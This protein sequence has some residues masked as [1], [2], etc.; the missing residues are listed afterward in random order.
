MTTAPR[1]ILT[2]MAIVAATATAVAVRGSDTV[3][4]IPPAASIDD[5]LLHEATREAVR[6]GLA[7]LAARA[8][9]EGN[10]DGY[11]RPMYVKLAKVDERSVE[12]RYSKKAF[13]VPT[14]ARKYREVEQLVPI[15]DEYGDVTGYRK[16]TRKIEVSK[17]KTGEKK[18]VREVRDPNGPIVK[19]MKIPIKERVGPAV[20]ERG[21]YGENAIAVYVYAKAGLGDHEVPERIADELASLIDTHGAPDTTWDLAWLIAAYA[22]LGDEQY[23]ELLTQLVSKLIDGQVRH[24]RSGYAGLWGPV[25]I[26]YPL[27]ANFFELELRVREEIKRIENRMSDLEPPMTQ[28]AKQLIDRYYEALGEIQMMLRRASQLGLT[29]QKITGTVKL[30][31]ETQIQGLPIFVYNRFLAD[32]DATAAAG[33]ALYA[34]AAAE[35]LPDASLRIAPAGKR[36]VAAESTARTIADALRALTQQQQRDGGWNEVNALE[37]NTTFDRS[38]IAIE[39]V[40]LREPLPTLPAFDTLA[41]DLAGYSAL[42]HL[43]LAEPRGTRLYAS[44]VQSARAP[45]LEAAEKILALPRWS[46]VASPVDVAAAQIVANKGPRRSMPRHAADADEEYIGYGPGPYPLLIHA[47]ALFRHA[48]DVE[49]DAAVEAVRKRLTLRILRQQR[50][51]GQWSARQGYGGHLT[52]SEI[53]YPMAARASVWRLKNREVTLKDAKRWAGNNV[54]ARTSDTALYPTLAALVFLVE[55]IEEPVSLDDVTILPEKPDEPEGKPGE[56]A[57]DEDEALMSPNEAASATLRPNEALLTLE[58][59]IDRVRGQGE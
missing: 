51:D 2:C 4:P 12:V 49:P 48:P 46:E 7:T 42:H 44:R 35:K 16:V 31:E 45:A 24:R 22:A 34:A 33:F 20:I 43:C 25:S 30:D 1:T 55:Q 40:P 36:I 8:L 27:L 9:A 19:Q 54:P 29:F 13:T 57:A 26:H 59:E 5:A 10:D 38:A 47:V 56:G 28:R 41:A 53:V 23:D 11:I 21:F 32:L 50:D 39:G 6:N 18:V 15:K 3:N 14:Y 58:S 17:T 37:A 52:S